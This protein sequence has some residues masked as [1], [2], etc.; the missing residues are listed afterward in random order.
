MGG[1][2]G[3]LTSSTEVDWRRVY[4][5]RPRAKFCASGSSSGLDILGRGVGLGPPPA[6][7]EVRICGIVASAELPFLTVNFFD[8][9]RRGGWGTRGRRCTTASSATA[10]PW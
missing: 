1:E 5:S 7:N 4:T 2:R 6:R 10:T 9:G 8:A 3:A